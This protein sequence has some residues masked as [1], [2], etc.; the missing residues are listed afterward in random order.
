V[1]NTLIHGGNMPAWLPPVLFAP[2]VGSFIGVLIVRLP[3]GRPVIFGRSLCDRCDH[4]L[5]ARDLIPILSY[6]ISRGRCRYCQQPIGPLLLSVELA[7]CCVALW[8]V[9][10]TEDNVWATCL[11]GWALLSLAWI[12]VRTMLLPDVITL[13]LVIAGLAV[14]WLSDPDAAAEHAIAAILGYLSLAAFAWSYRQLRRRDGVGM[15][16]AKL[17]AAAGAWLGLTV[18]PLTLFLAAVMGLFAAGCLWLRGA[19]LTATT[20][21]PFGPCLAAAI[22]LLWLYE[23]GRGD[24][25]PL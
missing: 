21:I 6:T 19:K 23:P 15:G 1:E 22:W 20:A 3:L 4:K 18:L 7:A 13:P 5:A 11:L 16:D 17:F 12:D 10:V 9:A 8:A 2:F 14:A 25:M 24:W